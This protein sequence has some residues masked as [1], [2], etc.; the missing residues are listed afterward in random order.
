MGPLCNQS[1]FSGRRA[2]ALLLTRLIVFS[3]AALAWP[4]VGNET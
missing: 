2:A 4:R 3:Q 1:P